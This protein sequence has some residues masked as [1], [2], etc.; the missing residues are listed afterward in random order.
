MRSTFMGPESSSPADKLE[1]MTSSRW[2]EID[3]RR[4]HLQVLF[5]DRTGGVRSRIAAGLF[6]RIAEW[7]GWGRILLPVAAGLHVNKTVD[8]LPSIPMSISKMAA[9]LTAGDA[10]GLW[11]KSLARPAESFDVDDL[12]RNDLIL[13]LDRSLH[14]EINDLILQAVPS[15]DWKYYQGKV[16]LLSMFGGYENDSTMLAS[17]GL[18]L[19]PR[20]LSWI[21]RQEFSSS[22]KVVDIASPDFSS[23]TSEKELSS[24]VCSLI[25]SCGGLCKYLMDCY[26]LDLP[27]YDPVD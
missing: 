17:G 20:Q 4:Y 8:G 9:I 22:K 10:L 14:K 1:E 6:E 26:P 2:P 21:L 12:D 18:A 11:T 13:V 23:D 27:D 16:C 7:N 24:M 15:E 3:W 5:L 19:L 25:L